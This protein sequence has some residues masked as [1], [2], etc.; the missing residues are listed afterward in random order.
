M[1][2]PTIT[3]RTLR[4][5]CAC[6]RGSMDGIAGGFNEIRDLERVVNCIMEL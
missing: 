1:L 3:L 4:Y 5:V 6:M 2:A